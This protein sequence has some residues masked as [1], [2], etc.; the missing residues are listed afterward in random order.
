ME[1]IMAQFVFTVHVME[2]EIAS[3][4]CAAI[5]VNPHSLKPLSVPLNPKSLLLDVLNFLPTYFC[6][7]TS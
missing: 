5:W 6:L 7:F 2:G 3:D 1:L 4:E